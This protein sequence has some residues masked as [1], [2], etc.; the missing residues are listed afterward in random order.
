MIRRLY[1]SNYRSIGEGLQLDLGNLTVLVGPNGSGKS[2]VTDALRFLADCLDR[3]LEQAVAAR[4]GFREIARWSPDH[5]REIEL[6][7][8]CERPHGEGFWGFTLA[9]GVEEDSFVVKREFASFW[10][11]GSDERQRP[12][13]DDFLRSPDGMDLPQQIFEGDQLRAFYRSAE[14]WRGAPGL[15]PIALHNT[16]LGLPFAAPTVS[17][18]VDEL[19]SVAVYVLFP[20]I[21]RA[22]QPPDP[23][24]PMRSS[25]DN[26]ASTLKALKR[27]AWGDELIAGLQRLVGDIDD[28][29]VAQAGGFLIPE[30]RHGTA[31]AGG[32]ERWFGAAQESD[33]TLR[34]AAMLTALFQEPALSLLGF[35]EPELAVHP[36]SIPVLFDFFQEACNRSQILLTTHSPDLLDLVPVD[37]LRVVDRRG[38]VTTVAR[39]EERQRDLVRQRLVSTSDLLHAEGLQ[40]EGT[41]R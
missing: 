12:A 3:S 10:P 17:N 1:V 37:D 26:W 39:V 20:N 23:T 30:F 18:L 34:L 22:P 40:P 33:G 16:S 21:L 36:G 4:R 13:L 29:R 7:V 19:R 27:P 15:V 2:N 6:A 25:G 41:P 24:R 9:A 38:G 14:G 8:E 32:R 5:P 11:R 35:E 31:G 28:Y